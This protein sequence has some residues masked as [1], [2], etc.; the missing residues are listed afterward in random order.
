MES[1]AFQVLLFV[2]FFTVYS[3]LVSKPAIV[4]LV[5]NEAVK[6]VVEP[7]VEADEPVISEEEI[8]AVYGETMTEELLP[9]IEEI[10]AAIT[11]ILGEPIRVA[12]KTIEREKFEVICPVAADEE[13]GCGALQT[14]TTRAL[15]DLA[16]GKIKGFMK[17]S[18]AEL[19]SAL[20]ELPGS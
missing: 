17:L 20:A 14:M 3:A 18:K 7:A 5:V 4:V 13:P 9:E 6:P 8:E 11:E 1:L 19:I 10:E 15:R 16:R 12:A 2:F